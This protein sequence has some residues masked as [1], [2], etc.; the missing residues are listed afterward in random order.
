MRKYIL[1]LTLLAP[2]PA[3]TGCDLVRAATSQEA[4]VTK[5]DAQKA[6]ALLQQGRAAVLRIETSYIRQTPC[7]DPG[8]PKPPLC[9]SYAV[10]LEMQSYNRA[11]A[12][13]LADANRRVEAGDVTAVEAAKAAY[14]TWKNFV[15]A[16]SGRKAQVES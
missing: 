15:E 8:A 9:A 4:I 5:A 10:G 13:S 1:I 11:F 6:L 7:T 14:A 3:A 12:A 16:K 2:L